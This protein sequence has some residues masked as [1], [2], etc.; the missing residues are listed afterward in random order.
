[1]FKMLA[2]VCAHVL[3]RKK[4]KVLSILTDMCFDYIYIRF[5]SLI[6][7]HSLFFPLEYTSPFFFSQ[8]IAIVSRSS[9]GGVGGVLGLCVSMHLLF[10]CHLASSDPTCCSTSLSRSLVISPT[11]LFN[12]PFFRSFR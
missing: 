11:V 12:R 4:K 2:S 1:M 8:L 9:K 3:V 10:L 6:R 5:N 7:Y